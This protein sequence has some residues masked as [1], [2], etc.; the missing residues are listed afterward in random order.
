MLQ[1]NKLKDAVCSR[2]KK[3]PNSFSLNVNLAAD[4]KNWERA[5]SNS[6][7]LAFRRRS[8][9]STNGMRKHMETLRLV[10]HW[11]HSTSVYSNVAFATLFSP[12]LEFELLFFSS[13]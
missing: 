5:S 10:A 2:Y 12:S 6:S 1:I 7:F 13:K 11:G 9:G 8:D 4:A 3:K